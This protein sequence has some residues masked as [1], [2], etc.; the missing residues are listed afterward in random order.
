MLQEDF[1]IMNTTGICADALFRR[2]SA[3]AGG[4][5]STP[6]S[7]QLLFWFDTHFFESCVDLLFTLE[8]RFD[9]QGQIPHVIHSGE[10]LGFLVDRGDYVSD[11]IDGTLRGSA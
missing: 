6:P 7:D 9:P 10:V 5:A 3:G 11:A 4:G 2:D 8:L 1:S